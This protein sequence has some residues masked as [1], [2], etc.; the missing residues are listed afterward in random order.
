MPENE[1]PPIVRAVFA[2]TVCTTPFETK[3]ILQPGSSG[4]FVCR[5]CGDELH[6]WSGSYGYAQDHAARCRGLSTDRQSVETS[7]IPLED[8]TGPPSVRVLPTDPSIGARHQS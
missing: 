4:T 2:C 7:S 8:Q 5:F 1:T 3:L 6:S